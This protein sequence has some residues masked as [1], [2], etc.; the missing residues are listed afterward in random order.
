MYK[1]FLAFL[2]LQIGSSTVLAAENV[3]TFDLNNGLKVVVIE[4]HRAPVVVHMLWYKVGAADEETGR[5]GVAHFLEHLLFKAT[6]RLKA[7]EFSSTVE[8]NG[9]SDN[10]FTSWDYTA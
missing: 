5:S 8:R 6:N 9:G 1:L 2:F 4:D 10:A 7:G 3:S